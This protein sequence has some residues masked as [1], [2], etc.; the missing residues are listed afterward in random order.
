M[1][2]GRKQV[3]PN[4]SRRSTSL[5]AEVDRR[6]K[7]ES[8]DQSVIDAVLG[9]ARDVRSNLGQDD[10]HRLEGYLESV[11]SVERRI[12]LTEI[13]RRE[14]EID[15]KNPGPSTLT[16][17]ENLPADAAGFTRLRR[18][19]EHDPDYHAQYIRLMSDL[20]VLAFQT[21]TTRV[22]TLSSPDDAFWPG[23]VT[24]GY[25]RH[26]HVMQHGGN[27]N[28]ADPI[29]REAL[30]QIHIWQ[31][32]LFAELVRKMKDIDEGGSS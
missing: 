16:R 10:R 3:V 26:Y 23:V 17:P 31:T 12:R 19:L 21:D 25:E 32:T 2:S 7:A 11:R 27:G 20:M 30:R 8:D 1:F 18:L 14:E 22:C 13:I 9:Q 5:S 28:P 4:G 15:E 29:A 6:E 24:V